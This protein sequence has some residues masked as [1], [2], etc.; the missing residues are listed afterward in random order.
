MDKKINMCEYILTVEL[1]SHTAHFRHPLYRS[2]HKTLPIM[3]PTA[4]KGIA[5][6]ALNIHKE[7]F[8]S[9]NSILNDIKV[10]IL[11]MSKPSVNRYIQNIQ[12]YKNGKFTRSIVTY[13]TLFKVHYKL[14]YGSND[15]RILEE[16]GKAFLTTE[17]VLYVGS[18]EDLVYICRVDIIEAKKTNNREFTGTIIPHVTRS[19]NYRFYMLFTDYKVKKS[20][21][22]V[23]EKIPC[24]PRPFIFLN[25]G[26][27]L[28]YPYINDVWEIDGRPFTWLNM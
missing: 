20:K 26:D 16:L 1:E 14:L 4:I 11:E 2:Y 6:K 19:S 10:S 21:K 3:P 27:Y 23:I 8:Y 7:E 22:G 15:F 17:N 25:Y 12:K 9:E 13:E 24:N 18:S 5:G 28:E